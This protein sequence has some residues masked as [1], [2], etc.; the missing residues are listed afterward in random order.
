MKAISWNVRGFGSIVKRGI[1]NDVIH[2]FRADL[3]LLQETKFNSMSYPIIKELW[4]NSQCRWVSLDAVGI[5]GGILLCCNSRLHTMK[6]HFIGASSVSAV[7][8]D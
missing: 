2:T 7:H 6:D 1:I 8:E 5:S 3:L 4:G